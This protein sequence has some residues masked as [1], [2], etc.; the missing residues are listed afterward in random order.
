MK[1]A[2]DRSAEELPIT[3]SVP[4]KF[5]VRQER[6]FRDVLKLLEEGH[7][8]FAV[9]G[10]FALQQHTGICRS[11]K[12]LDVFLTSEDISRSLGLLADHDFRSEITDPVWLAKASRGEYFVDL[13]AGMSNGAIRV[14]ESW[15]RRSRP[16]TILGVNTR[17]L[18]PE[19]LIA[20]KLFVARRERFDGADIAH[21]IFGTHG[22]LDWE[23][24]LELAGEH[25]ELVLWHLVLF[26]YIYPAYDHYVPEQIWQKLLCRFADEVQSPERGA[27][28][29]GSLVDHRMFAIDVDEWGLDDMLKESQERSR[30]I[31]HLHLVPKPQRR[32]A[33]RSRGNA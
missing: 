15:I 33:R 1:K 26:H 20:L 14:D 2:A 24:V 30:K 29:R 13:I 9:T 8:P 31:R 21:V 6:L 12:D 32:R 25:W 18:A 27:R 22:K 28:F 17:V 3:S 16:A 5:P 10:G 7:V 11:T 23:R 19:E 4:V